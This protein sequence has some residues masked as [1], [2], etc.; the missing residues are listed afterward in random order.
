MKYYVQLLALI[1]VVKTLR[2]RLA[3]VE[4]S[5]RGHH[6]DTVDTAS[7]GHLG[8]GED[9]GGGV[10]PHDQAEAGGEGRQPVQDQHS[11]LNM[12]IMYMKIPYTPLTSVVIS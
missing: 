8:Q 1:T 10:G 2:E 5:L 6:E 7:E 12:C 3:D 4:I 11:T 9:D